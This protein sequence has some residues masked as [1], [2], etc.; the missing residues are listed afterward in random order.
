MGLLDRLRASA[1]RAAPPSDPDP[2]GDEVQRKLEM[3]A[4]VSR[5]VA[6]GRMRAE[7]RTR[8]RGS[9]IEFADHREYVPGDDFRFVDWDVYRRFGRLLV[10]LYEEEEDLQILLVVDC[11]S[12]M[13]FGDGRKLLQA[14]RLAAGLAYVG[15]ANLDRV[16][17][18]GVTGAVTARLAP[19]RGRARIFKVFR[20]LRG[21]RAGGRT[22]LGAALATLVAGQARRG[23]AVLLSDLYDPAGFERGIDVLRYHRFEP[24]V[25]HVVDPADGA[26]DARG[27]VSLVDCETGEERDVTVTE[28][29][30]ARLRAAHE[31]YLADVER[32][33]RGRQVPYLRAPVDRP[34]DEL[35]LRVFRE[36]GFLRG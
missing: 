29:L 5:R 25:V 9:G 10:R 11:S 34:F 30:L 6:A 14:R 2:F 4:L 13:G 24:Y 28:G 18:A 12:S 17:L 1:P 3:L 26:P 35:I 21:L 20:F 19:V 23:V 15:L 27:D 16:T 22:D 33:C 32:Y 8:K 36:G 31:G 7:R